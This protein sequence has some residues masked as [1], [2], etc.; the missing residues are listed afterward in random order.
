MSLKRSIAQII[1]ISPEKNYNEEELIDLLVELVNYFRPKKISKIETISIHSLITQL[2]SDQANLNLLAHHLKKLLQGKRFTTILADAGIL[3]DTNFLGE[4]KHRIISRIL[5]EQPEKDTLEY[6][7]NQVFYKETDILWLSKIPQ[8]E[9]LE[10]AE[11]IGLDS[12]YIS[13]EENS[14]LTEILNAITLIIQ[15][16]SGRALE[17]DILRM[18]PEYENTRSPF[19]AFEQEF[20]LLEEKIRSSESKSVNSIDQNYV[21]LIALMDQCYAFVEKAYE[22]SKVIGISMKV[23]QNLLRIRQQ[24][25]RISVLIPLLAVDLPIEKKNN[26]LKLSF[27]LIKYNCFKNNIQRLIEDS[28]STI[29][30]EITK[31]TAK[32]GEHYITNDQ[33]EYFKMFK[34]ALGGGIIVGLLCIIKL[35]L[36]KTEASDFGYAFLYSMN[37][38]LGFIAIYLLG[39]TLATKQPAMTASAIVESIDRGKKGEIDE[40]MQHAAFAELFSRLFRSQFIAFIG[41]VVAALPV[42]LLGTYLIE[43]SIN[44]NIAETKWPKMIEDISPIDSKA[45][46]HAGIAGIFL[47]LSGVISGSISNRHKFDRIEHRIKEH[48]LLKRTIGK[49]RSAKIASWVS[50]KW[51]AVASNF[52]FGIFMGSTASVGIFLGLDLDIRHITFASGNLGLSLYGSDFQLSTD[53]LFWSVIGIG[54]IGFMNFIVSFML[55]LTLA[56]RSRKIPFSELK[57]LFASVWWYFKINPQSFFY[58]TK[59]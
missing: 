21:Q 13:L 36:S 50:K 22:N 8:E 2:K 20:D 15:R 12:I 25:D 30:F 58:P 37:Y 24:L 52:W 10:L 56:M 49:D 32:T 1:K 47:F 11:L 35:L 41:N 4:V 45:I 43:L 29:A 57:F 46:F 26:S 42:A 16:I 34:A 17:S 19:E 9:I 3:R 23:N 33:R 53:M 39:F 5:P 7:L 40:Q 59:N 31:H 14:P 48:P 38:S 6:I 44:Y 18:N 28:T 51:P 27:H 54:V 55:S